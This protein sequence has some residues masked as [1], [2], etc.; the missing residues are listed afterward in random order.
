MHLPVLAETTALPHFA[1]VAVTAV[2]PLDEGDVHDLADQR[3]R[4]GRPHGHQRAEYHPRRHLDHSPVLA[5]LVD[6]RLRQAL[7]QYLLWLLGPPR[8]PRPWLG[9]FDRI[10]LEERRRLRR[11]F[12][13]GHPVHEPAA[14]PRLEVMHPLM[15]LGV[16]A[17]ARNYAP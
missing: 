5:F 3:G 7:G 11:V 14:R 4:Q 12:V 2:V 9:L 13:R 10:G 16:G 17:L 8:P 1:P 6:R 15:H